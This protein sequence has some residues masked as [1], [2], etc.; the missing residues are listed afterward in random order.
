MNI[1][2]HRLFWTTVALPDLLTSNRLPRVRQHGRE[3]LDRRRAVW[4]SSE[5][6]QLSQH[7]RHPR[8]SQSI[9]FLRVTLVTVVL[10]VVGSQVRV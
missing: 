5:A 9:R 2:K 7:G 8:A 6:T 10:V 1:S 4:T 3:L